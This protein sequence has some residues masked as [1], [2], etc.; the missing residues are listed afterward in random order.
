MEI[1][2]SSILT[3]STDDLTLVCLRTPHYPSYG[4]SNDPNYTEN[5]GF[6]MPIHMRLTKIM[7]MQM[8]LQDRG[9]VPPRTLWPQ[10]SLSFYIQIFKLS[11]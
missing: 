4:I 3:I 10:K 5:I 7:P 9:L 1:Y 6:R 8:F 2:S 11:R